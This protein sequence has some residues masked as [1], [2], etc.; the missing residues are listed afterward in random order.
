MANLADK[1]RLNADVNKLK[2]AN[3]CYK[4]NISA[5]N[6]G[7][8]ATGIG[9]LNEKRIHAVLKEYFE[10]RSKYH[11]VPYLGYVADI[12]NTSGVIEIQTGSLYPLKAKLSSFIEKTNVTLVHPVA[13]VKYLSWIDPLTG[14]ISSRRK[15]PK[16][17]PVV[18]SLVNL[19]YIRQFLSQPRL[20]I[21]L[22][23]LEV[24]EYRYKNGWSRDGKRGSTRYDIVPLDLIDI[25]SLDTPADYLYFLPDSLKDANEFTVRD[26][27][28][29]TKVS[30]RDAYMVLSTMTAACALR[31]EKKRGNVNIYTVITKKNKKA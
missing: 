2:F 14:D 26:F 15:S 20:M 3:I 13:A 16:T 17:K 31:K 28:E 1:A 9:I 29:A 11:E 19:Y 5:V 22:V 30:H 27:S 23:L 6:K 25:I 18:S 8:S 24:D 7:N 21:R 4:H 12:K 10:P